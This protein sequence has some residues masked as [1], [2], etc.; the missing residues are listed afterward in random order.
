LR[1]RLD[2]IYQQTFQDFEVILL[3]DA[4][5]DETASILREYADLHAN[6][7]LTV[8]EINGGSTFSQWVKGLQKARADIIWIA[9]DD[10]FS[11]NKFLETL[12][13]HFADQ[14][15]KL[16]YCQS[17]AVDAEDNILFNYQ[18]YTDDLSSERWKKPY[19]VSAQTEINL[20]L[21]KK[22]TIPNASAVLF[23]KFDIE[24]WAAEWIGQ[25]LAGDWAFYLYALMG[26]KIAFYPEVLN[27]HRRHENT[28]IK[29][30][31][32][33]ERRFI[34][35][36]N[37]QKVVLELYDVESSVRDLMRQGSLE[38]WQIVHPQRSEEEFDEV[39]QTILNSQSKQM[40]PK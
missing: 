2:S 24:Q 8:N 3:D 16:A 21:A 34:E 9:E 33:D 4:S 12:L 6:T 40:Q 13:P 5:T 20:A 25:H 29:R 19:I 30:Y 36:A 15:I 18:Q 14:E 10:D 37:V 1:Q 32:Y 27:Y 26:G 38:N 11:D 17:C 39:Y 7:K 23:R 31:E 28:N 22:N 35:C